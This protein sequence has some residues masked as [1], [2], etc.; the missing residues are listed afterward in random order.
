MCMYVRIESTNMYMYVRI[1]RAAESTNMCMYVRIE[2]TNMCMYVRI[3]RAA[4]RI[5]AL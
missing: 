5:D 2:S 1:Q 3:Q 4:E